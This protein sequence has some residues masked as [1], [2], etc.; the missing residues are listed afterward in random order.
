MDLESRDQVMQQLQRNRYSLRDVDAAFR[1]DREVVRFAVSHQGS[2][3]Q[4]AS[5]ELRA[6]RDVVLQAIANHG[7]ALQWASVD[8]R[9]N[10]QVVVRAVLNG[11]LALQ[12]ASEELRANRDVVLKAISRNGCALQWASADLRADAEVVM[13]AVS[14]HTNALAYALGDTCSNR[15]IVVR[16]IGSMDR[17]SFYGVLALASAELRADRAVVTLAVSKVGPALSHASEDLRDDPEMMRLAVQNEPP[18]IQTLQYAS[19]AWRGQKPFVLECIG[20]NCM[21]YRHVAPSLKD[22]R[23][24]VLATFASARA[25]QM[26][27]FG[28]RL[29]DPAL[30]ADKQV[31]LAAVDCDAHLLTRASPEL[32]HDPDIVRTALA[33]G[34]RMDESTYISRTQMEELL[35]AVPPEFRNGADYDACV[36]RVPQLAEAEDR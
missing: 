1:K 2:Q 29:V 22:D 26:P 3:L 34:C 21:N 9:A 25:Q 23:D 5:E 6:N 10:A 18:L 31:M 4:Y 16:A 30:C 17:F 8:L 19:A 14:Q 12:F 35:A 7:D 27:M 28:A 11:A 13:C 20:R 24:V 33:A 32:Q 15:D 36:Q